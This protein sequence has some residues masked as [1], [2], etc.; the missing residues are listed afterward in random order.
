MMETKA[1]PPTFV[2]AS[3][4]LRRHRRRIGRVLLWLLVVPAVVTFVLTHAAMAFDDFEQQAVLRLDHFHRQD[5][6]LLGE[7]LRNEGA[8]MEEIDR[9][10]AALDLRHEQARDAEKS[11]LGPLLVPFMMLVWT[12]SF[13]SVPCGCI[14]LVI[15]MST[16]A[17]RL[18]MRDRMHRRLLDRG[19]EWATRDD[20]EWLLLEE[21]RFAWRIPRVEET[22]VL[23]GIHS[24]VDGLV[25]YIRLQRDSKFER[26]LPS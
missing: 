9:Q 15:A 12:V 10:L 18:V 1:T 13:F 5:R 6:N 14:V 7:R 19:Y 26:T 4:R 17:Y 8:P 24:N 2:P 23:P 11:I 16:Y 25:A 21:P 22:C 3:E 20:A